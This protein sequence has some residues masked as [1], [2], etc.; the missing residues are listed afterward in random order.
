MNELTDLLLSPRDV[1]NL[2]HLPSLP[3]LPSP[4]LDLLSQE[5]QMALGRGPKGRRWT[6][7]GP[8]FCERPASSTPSGPG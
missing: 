5:R 3:D 1:I 2:A 4:Y 6:V 8:S 7:L